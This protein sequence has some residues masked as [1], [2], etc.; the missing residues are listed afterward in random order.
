MDFPVSKGIGRRR[1]RGFLLLMSGILLIGGCSLGTFLTGWEHA[2]YGTTVLDK[3]IFLREAE[4]REDCRNGTLDLTLPDRSRQ[5]NSVKYVIQY[6]IDGVDDDMYITFFGTDN[7]LDVYYDLANWREPAWTSV[8]SDLRIHAGFYRPYI[9]SPST[10]ELSP[11]DDITSAVSAFLAG[12]ADPHI[13]VSGHSAGGSHAVICA[14]DLNVSIPALDTDDRIYCLIGGAPAVGNA[15]FVSVFDSRLGAD[16]CHRYV[17]GSDQ[18]PFLFTQ[19]AGFY[20]VGDPFRVGPEPN[21]L[22]AAS[23]AWLDHHFI[24]DYAESI[25]AF[26]P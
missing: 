3:S 25:K 26:N 6:E 5:V 13:Y 12:A 19:E 7:P 10:G 17:N 8:A 21:A 18:M 20:Q 15:K 2:V 9:T 23:G 22:M 4:L 14:F 1:L 11:A 24:A 16:S